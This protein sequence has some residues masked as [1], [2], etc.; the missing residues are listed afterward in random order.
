M[1]AGDGTNRPHLERPTA[2]RFIFSLKWA[3]E[4][5]V[6]SLT[7]PCQVFRPERLYHKSQGEDRLLAC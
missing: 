6:T 7:T 5:N 2:G 1:T 4:E 3:W